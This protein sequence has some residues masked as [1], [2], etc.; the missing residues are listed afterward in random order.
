MSDQQP[1]EDP[2]TPADTDVVAAYRSGLTIAEVAEVYGQSPHRIAQLI[3]SERALRARRRR[4]LRLVSS[5]A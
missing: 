5:R 1:G 4:A 3:L 2:T